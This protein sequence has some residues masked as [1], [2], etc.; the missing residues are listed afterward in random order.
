MK[1][2]EGASSFN[3][4]ISNWNTSNVGTMNSMFKDAE[5][6]NQ[7][8]R[9]WDVSNVSDQELLNMFQNATAM[10]AA[11]TDLVDNEHATNLAWFNS[12]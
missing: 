7:D 2:F 8:I 4:D 6:F 1:M 10:K 12:D 11:F 5:A 9:K 3:K